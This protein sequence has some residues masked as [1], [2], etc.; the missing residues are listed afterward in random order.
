M[1]AHVFLQSAFVLALLVFANSSIQAQRGDKITIQGLVVDYAGNPMK[2][3]HVADTYSR[4]KTKTDDNGV[5]S[6]QLI[7]Q[8]SHLRFSHVGYKTE[9]RVI[10]EPVLRKSLPFTHDIIVMM[11]PNVYNIPEA[12]VMPDEPVE[13][14]A[15]E[16]VSVLDFAFSRETEELLVLVKKN[17]RV[18]LQQLD[19]NFKVTKES[20]VSASAR[21]FV[22]DC[23]GNLHLNL[24]KKVAQIV[25]MPDGFATREEESRLEFDRLFA[26]C[27]SSNDKI[28]VFAEYSRYGNALTYF[29]IDRE[30]KEKI[31]LVTITD[32]VRA[33]VAENSIRE[34]TTMFRIFQRY[35][36][37]SPASSI[38]AQLMLE[39]MQRGDM[40]AVW[41]NSRFISA[42]DVIHPANA[43]PTFWSR[44]DVMANME[45]TPDFLIL[46][47]YLRKPIYEPLFKTADGFTVFDHVNSKAIKLSKSG[48]RLEGVSITH[49]EMP[50]W[51]TQVIQD[52]QS[53]EFYSKSTLMGFPLISLI[54][55]DNGGTN[56]RYVL[57]SGHNPD[58]L[59]IKDGKAYFLAVDHL[60]PYR[61]LFVWHFKE[62]SADLTQ[63]N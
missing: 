8:E 56:S 62:L 22:E 30:T 5:F 46:W 15:P 38:Q 48:E 3:V 31:E 51:K 41:A 36:Y 59:K 63:V 27:V 7:V 1:K 19:D 44:P 50:G 45:L 32:E 6:I 52:F 28:A 40:Q 26:S 60:S 42:T 43:W 2:D 21:G 24:D 37:L 25:E 49:H 34:V 16:N 4:K 55:V 35:N 9:N 29:S 17:R 23:L 13:R 20:E 47:M 12:I 10:E 58:V 11:V 61:K 39:N 14:F 33:R 18:F 57:K 54:D 53:K